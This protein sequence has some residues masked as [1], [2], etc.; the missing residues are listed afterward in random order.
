MCSIFQRAKRKSNLLLELSITYLIKTFKIFVLLSIFLP[1]NSFG[2]CPTFLQSYGDDCDNNCMPR[3]D[4]ECGKLRVPLKFHVY[5]NNSITDNNIHSFIQGVNSYLTFSNLQLIFFAAEIDR[6][7]SSNLETLCQ[8]FNDCP[9]DNDCQDIDILVDIGSNPANNTFINVFLVENIKGFAFEYEDCSNNNEICQ[10]FRVNALANYPGVSNIIVARNS[11]INSSQL[12][13][14]AHELGHSLGLFHTFECDGED[15]FDGSSIC[16]SND[17]ISDIEPNDPNNLMSYSDLISRN[18]SISPEATFSSCQKAKMYDVLS[19]C[20]SNLAWPLPQPTIEFSDNTFPTIASSGSISLACNTS[21]PILASTLGSEGTNTAGCTEWK[22]YD[23]TNNFLFKVEQINEFSPAIYNEF[24]IP[25]TYR[26]EVRD[27]GIYNPNNTSAP[28]II[29]V[30]VEECLIDCTL[31]LS[32]VPSCENDEY[33][34]QVS[35][36]ENNGSGNFL[37]QDNFSTSN[38]ITNAQPNTPYL[39]GPYPPVSPIVFSVDDVAENY[40]CSDLTTVILSN[41]ECENEITC[42]LDNAIY[43]IHSVDCSTNRLRIS[44]QADPNIVYQAIA[45]GEWTTIHS[46]G[47]SGWIPFIANN[48]GVTVTIREANDFS[49]SV[50]IPFTPDCETPCTPPSIELVDY[51]CTGNNEFELSISFF[52]QINESYDLYTSPPSNTFNNVNSGTFSFQGFS[53]QTGNITVFVQQ[54]NE[55]SCLDS[56]TFVN[57]VNCSDD[58]TPPVITSVQKICAGEGSYDLRVSFSG[59]DN[60]V[61]DLYTDTYGINTHPDV[62]PGTYYFTGFNTLAPVFIHVEA[63][64]DPTCRDDLSYY[65]SL[66]PCTNLSLNCPSPCEECYEHGDEVSL[67]W[68]TSGADHLIQI[69]LCE[70]EGQCYLQYFGP[71][72]GTTNLEIPAN[73]YGEFYYKIQLLNGSEAFGPTFQIAENCNTVVP[74]TCTFLTNPS[75]GAINV[76]INTTLSWMAIPDADGYLLSVSTPSTG[77]ILDN[78]DIIGGTNNS[79]NLPESLPA[80][81]QVTVTIIPYNAGGTAVHCSS[82]TFMT[83]DEPAECNNATFLP[84][85]SFGNCT[86]SQGTNENA[87]D[88]GE[89]TPACANYGGADTWYYFIV[90]PSGNLII[91]AYYIST[92]LDWNMA[93]YSGSC[94]NLQ[95]IA[96]AYSL[97]SQLDNLTSILTLSNLTPGETL[98]LR[99]WDQN[100]D[101]TGPFELCAYEF[102]PNLDGGYSWSYGVMSE[103]NSDDPDFLP[104]NETNTF[105]VGDFAYAN[106]EVVDINDDFVR[107]RIQ[108]FNAQNTLIRDFVFGPYGSSEWHRGYISFLVN[109][110]GTWRAD[111]YVQS[112]GSNFQIQHST[113]FAV[114]GNANLNTSENQNNRLINNPI[115]SART[116]GKGA[117][118]GHTNESL[119][120]QESGRQLQLYPNPAKD[121]LWLLP[122]KYANQQAEIRILDNL[123]RTLQVLLNLE[124]N[125]IV[126]IDIKHLPNG[127]YHLVVNCNNAKPFVNKFVIMK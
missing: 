113:S 120:S 53:N 27:K 125:E 97:T 101:Q 57:Q 18:Q 62:S 58:C 26:I 122:G 11:V 43:A 115:F 19:Q 107:E 86:L 24:S 64:S 59:Q 75:N 91:E 87:T 65:E 36:S 35:F 3:Y 121:E 89:Q 73:F 31:D 100:G 15:S 83:A 48:G 25:G 124:L 80:N 20:R 4:G 84:I 104:I 85:G 30:T 34:V 56:Y 6:N 108:I 79:F 106:F 127:I 118:I 42:S 110:P 74:P 60:L 98:Y 52:G 112:Q 17:G 88:S 70:T 126:S 61:Y 45:G 102:N 1:I 114:V 66:I 95:E 116:G 119:L 54:N 63:D 55:A 14:F 37:L 40:L 96:C 105:S 90:P 5:P 68:Q 77:L 13:I 92:F 111:F 33:F 82:E 78:I 38:T 39:F 21:W 29:N 103:D 81:T 67:S 49:C 8:S 76:N 69:F 99:L 16:L 72:F 28:T 10:N 46:N 9:Q 41:V 32:A 123:G 93:A 44:L 50:S 47:I 117:A 109:T 7:L 2:Q 51:N 23:G 12:A 94:N 22:V 71:N